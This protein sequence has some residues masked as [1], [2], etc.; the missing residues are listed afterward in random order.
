L[1]ARIVDVREDETT[2]VDSTINPLQ[3]SV[4]YTRMIDTATTPV[5]TPDDADVYDGSGSIK[6]APWGL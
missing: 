1:G 4:W 6:D 2:R 5:L 3:I